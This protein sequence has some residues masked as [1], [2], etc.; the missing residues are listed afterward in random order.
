MRYYLL[1][2]IVYASNRVGHALVM[3]MYTDELD[4]A[5]Q[6]MDFVIEMMRSSHLYHLP[7]IKQQYVLKRP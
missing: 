1:L 3:W 5:S 6:N 2:V 4:L 7:D